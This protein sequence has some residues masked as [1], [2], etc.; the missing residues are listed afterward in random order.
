MG[1]V[2][3]IRER[4]HRSL[5]D[6]TIFP[7][8]APELARQLFRL[9]VLDSEASVMQTHYGE[10]SQKPGFRQD[11]FERRDFVYLVANIV[12]A[13]GVVGKSDTA[14]LGT[15][16]CFR[17]LVNAELQRRWPMN[18]ASADE[19][20]GDAAEDLAQL[21]SNDPEAN[22]GLP[23]KWAQQWL[24]EIG[25]EESNLVTLFRVSYSWSLC[26]LTVAKFLHRVRLVPG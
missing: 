15:M 14:F 3:R 16:P 21:I 22:R 19:Q 1:F 5:T 11:A 26:Y 17:R 18:N 25:V 9:F 23:I 12:V 20:I 24:R 6:T 7:I 4:I 13:V 8:T 2:R 10:L